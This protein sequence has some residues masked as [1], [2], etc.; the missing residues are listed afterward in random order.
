MDNELPGEIRNL[1]IYDRALTD[2]EMF[3]CVREGRFMLLRWWW[4]SLLRK[5]HGR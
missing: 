5:V 4:Y 1:Q 2:K 3:Y